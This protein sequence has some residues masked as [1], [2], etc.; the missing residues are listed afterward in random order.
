MLCNAYDDMSNFSIRSKH[1]RC[2][3]DRPSAPSNL[4]VME[5]D[6]D[7][8][9][10]PNPLTDWRIPYLDYLLLKVLLT[11]KMEARWLARRAKSFVIIQVELYK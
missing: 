6:E 2:Y 10:E 1:Q 7:Q 11:D 4:E 5:L 9:A 8:V 3:T